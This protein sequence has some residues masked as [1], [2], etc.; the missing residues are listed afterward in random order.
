MALDES[1]YRNRLCHIKLL[2]DVGTY[3]ADDGAGTAICAAQTCTP[4]GLYCDGTRI[5]QCNWSGSSGVEVSDCAVF[6]LSCE[7]GLCQ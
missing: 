1:P 2:C 6:G 4:G 7:A 3:C 5:N